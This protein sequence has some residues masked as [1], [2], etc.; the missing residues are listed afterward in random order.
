MTDRS[1]LHQ[2]IVN[3]HNLKEFR[4]FCFRL[5]LRYDDLGGERV[6]A[7]IYINTAS[8]TLC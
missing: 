4:T 6:S 3:R 8:L 1:R 2:F 7:T 5:G